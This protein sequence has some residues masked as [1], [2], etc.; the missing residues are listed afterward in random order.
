MRDEAAQPGLLSGKG[1]SSSLPDC[2]RPPLSGSPTS[3]LPYG[4]PDLANIASVPSVALSPLAP[5]LWQLPSPPSRIL[6]P[7]GTSQTLHVPNSATFPA[8][9]PGTLLYFGQTGRLPFLPPTLP[10]FQDPC[11]LQLPLLPRMPSFLQTRE[12]L[13]NNLDDCFQGKRRRK[14]KASVSRDVEKSELCALLTAGSG[15]PC[16]KQCGGCSES[17]R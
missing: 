12:Y 2:P 16:G 17:Q 9:S 15:Q 1:C 11:S 8:S 4:Q 7:P 14:R 3:C 10:I 13:S 6:A 5:A